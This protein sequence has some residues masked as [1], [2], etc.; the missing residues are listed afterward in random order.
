MYGQK[1]IGSR[2]LLVVTP[3]QHLASSNQLKA[4]EKHASQIQCP[5]HIRTIYM[6]YKSAL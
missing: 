6:F 3:F 2:P 5:F 4:A 1:K